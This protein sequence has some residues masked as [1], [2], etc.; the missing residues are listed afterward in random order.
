MSRKI[1]FAST[2][3]AFSVSLSLSLS[4]H[5]CSSFPCC[6]R[7]LMSGIWR[8]ILRTVIFSHRYIFC[9]PFSVFHA[10]EW[11]E[12]IPR[13]WGIS[14]NCFHLYSIQILFSVYLFALW[15][16]KRDIKFVKVS[17]EKSSSR[18]QRFF[19]PFESVRSSSWYWKVFEF[20]AVKSR[21]IPTM[22]IG[23]G[24]RRRFLRTMEMIVFPIIN[25][26]R[27]TEGT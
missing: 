27:C 15:I 16:R 1:F 18:F 11:N 3:L 20:R 23:S 4:L 22:F 24:T 7:Y 8:W 19:C 5:F 25:L 6:R 10:F 17:G 2:F 13:I 26:E 21:I 12:H 9:Q 14:I